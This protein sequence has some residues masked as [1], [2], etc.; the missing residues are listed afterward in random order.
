[1]SVTGTDVR[2]TGWPTMRTLGPVLIIPLAVLLAIGVAFLAA[3]W[4]PAL[5]TYPEKAVV[6][7]AEWISRLFA[8]F[9]EELSFGLFT[10]SQLMDGLIFVL[11]IPLTLTE[12]LLYEGFSDLGIAPLPWWAV[13]AVL[14]VIGH[15][16]GGWRKVIFIVACAMVLVLFQ[17]WDLAMETLSLVM[18]AAPFTVLVGGLIGIAA[19]RHPRL[20]AVLSPILSLMQA[21][22]Q[23][24]YLL[25]VVVLFGFGNEP[26]LIAMMIFALAPMVRC[27]ILGLKTV[28]SDALEAGRMSGCSRWQLLRKVE[29][30]EA[31]K[32]ILVGVNQVVNMTLAMVVIASLIG[33]TGLGYDLLVA[34]ERLQ[35]GTAT[36]L[37]I[38]VVLIAIIL[39]RIGQSYT[40]MP[41]QHARQARFWPAR[42]PHLSAIG[43]I[44]LF[45]LLVAVVLPQL[46]F[47]PEALT[48]HAAP[49]ID[50]GVRWFTDLMFQSLRSF[51]FFF[52]SDVLI[53]VRDALRALPWIVVVVAVAAV[54]YGI[55]GRRL[56]AIVGL[57]AALPAL[58]GFWQPTMTSVYMISVAIGISLLAGLPLGLLAAGNE[59]VGRVAMT[60][61]DVMQTFPSFVYLIPAIMLFRVGDTAAI[62]AVTIY[63]TI[64]VVRYTNLGLRRVPAN[65]LE[66]ARMSGCTPLQMLTKVRVP[67]AMPEILLGINQAVMLGLFMLAIASLIGTSDLGQEINRALSDGDVGRGLTAGMLM[68]T[69]GIIVDQ[70]IRTW[71]EGRKRQL[72]LP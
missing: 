21:M 68:A 43:G 61:C 54:G 38:G 30:P 29:L 51:N 71:S 9:T 39:D 64:P 56:A 19:A 47:V 32:T 16:V 13:I 42:H 52:T 10:F 20:E 17:I 48:L 31:Q 66:A 22:P 72:G 3:R 35:I 57:L 70:L 25:P 14:A 55:G 34:L 26:G 49:W 18:V 15:Y 7:L 24:A 69:I 59:R 62:L 27:M 23:F 65:T 58:V 40:E 11:S 5:D 36:E 63:A 1:M 46:A 28:P 50:A 6:P 44:A 2:R 67:M 33:V 41:Y 45:G 53:P 8:W 4:W 12:G 37:G 60:A